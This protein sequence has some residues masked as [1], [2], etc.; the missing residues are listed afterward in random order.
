MYY[1]YLRGYNYRNKRFGA[2]FRE[3]KLY[4]LEYLY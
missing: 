1:K 3:K 4:E 2:F